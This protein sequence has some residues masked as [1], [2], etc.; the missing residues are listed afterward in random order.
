MK[1]K[2]YAP[3]ATIL[4][5]LLAAGIALV[6]DLLM[7]GTG[8][9]QAPA[10]RH[11]DFLGPEYSETR[12]YNMAKLLV[13][14]MGPMLPNI[15]PTARMP[16]QSVSETVRGAEP[17]VRVAR[18]PE[19]LPVKKPAGQFWKDHAVTGVAPAGKSKIVIIIDDMGMGRKH[20]FEVMDLPAPLTLAFLPYAPGLE[21]ITAQARARGHEL[22]IHAPM[23]P[24]GDM[25][26]GPVALLDSMPETELNENL[27]KM[28]NS[29]SGYVGINNHMG[30][31][32][33]QNEAAMHVVMNALA[34]RGLIFV[35]SKTIS[36]SVAAKVAAEHGL[37]YAERD[38]FLDH[39]DNI[40]FVRGALLNL[41]KH[42]RAYG[43]AVAIGH[44]K[45]ATIAALKEWIP[46]AEQRGF[47]IVPVS[48][49]VRR[50][51]LRPL[52]AVGAPVSGEIFG[53]RIPVPK[54]NPFPLQSPQP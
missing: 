33:T 5:L 47:V 11:D 38:V 8:P 2:Y 26:P 29:F 32:L 52:A 41:E 37:D 43:A 44:P 23:E 3:R 19:N 53:P 51:P 30:S 17:P 16:S 46:L 24:M 50:A 9:E 13:E 7:R 34:E 45:A 20:S 6:A 10:V 21:E 36:T 40:D 18:L 1:R 35:D 28:F 31:K 15:A 12:D 14:E 4:F 42:A 25:N 49:V 39:E 22:L 48:A 54:M 27:D